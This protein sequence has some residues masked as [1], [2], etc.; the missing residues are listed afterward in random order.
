MNPNVYLV[1][2]IF[3]LR[4][5][6]KHIWNGDNQSQRNPFEILQRI[7]YS[8][9]RKSHDIRC[10]NDFDE[11]IFFYFQNV[12]NCSTEICQKAAC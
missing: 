7:S 5:K 3:P 11:G 9:I 8:T 10:Q 1:S 4:Q 6:R 2:K 12:E